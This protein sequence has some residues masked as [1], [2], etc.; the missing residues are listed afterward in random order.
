M[1]VCFW[2]DVRCDN[3]VSTFESSC[4]VGL[5]TEVNFERV[6]EA[7]DNVSLCIQTSCSV[8]ILT[9]PQATC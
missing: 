3:N 9:N 7:S 2:V 8:L 4:N 5:M 1:G 6:L